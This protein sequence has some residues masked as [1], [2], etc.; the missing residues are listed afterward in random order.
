MKVDFK[1]KI[2]MGK[3]AFLK[4]IVVLWAA[5]YLA[6][7]VAVRELRFDLLIR[8]EYLRNDRRRTVI[9]RIGQL[10]FAIL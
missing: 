7:Q 1:L 3:K 8:D 10:P 2:K 6:L 9:Y 5:I 4:Y